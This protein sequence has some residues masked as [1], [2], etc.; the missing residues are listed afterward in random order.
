[1]FF[2]TYPG[3]QGSEAVTQ[4]LLESAV[5]IANLFFLTSDAYAP[6][7]K[8]TD[9]SEDKASEAILYRN[10]KFKTVATYL[11]AQLA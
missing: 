11:I 7:I 2:A 3:T 5:Y 10:C 6:I 9:L 4:E 8:D 1:M